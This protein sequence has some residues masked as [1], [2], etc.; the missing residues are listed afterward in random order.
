MTPRPMF[1][2]LCRA[3]AAN[4]GT[5]DVMANR[6]MTDGVPEESL[7]KPFWTVYAPEVRAVLE[8]MKDANNVFYGVLMANGMER[9]NMRAEF[10][11]AIQAILDEAG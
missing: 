9:K 11:A 1:E 6:I 8:A 10:V 4:D 2:T 3:L 5:S 7:G